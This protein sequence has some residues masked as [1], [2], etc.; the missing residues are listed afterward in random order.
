MST[1]ICVGRREAAI[2]AVRHNGDMA[3]LTVSEFQDLS[4]PVVLDV[5][6]SLAG[7]S[8]TADYAAGR[9]PGAVFVDFDGEICGPPGDGGR[10][11]LPDPAVLEATLRRVGVDD[12]STV[13]VYDA[14]DMMSA[15][16]TWWTLKWA[17]L[18]NVHVL[19]G[20]YAAAVEAGLGGDVTPV[21]T[22]EGTTTV[23]PGILPV[24]DAEGAFAAANEGVLYDVR[25]PARFRGDDG[26]IDPVAGHVP[27]AVNLPGE[28]VLCPD[29]V[30][31]QPVER[32]A[33][34]FA[35]VPAIGAGLYCGSGVTA[36]RTALAATV[37]GLA[38]PAVYIGSWSE[39]IRDE[40]RPVA[41]GDDGVD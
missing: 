13:V 3:L 16:R 1:I 28:E 36:A 7:G 12:D 33:E 19:D 15:S 26:V 35:G 27:G 40:S 10:H 8:G 6:W 22:A 31:F 21:Q 2:D 29:G 32:L 38:T 9:L 14:G 34:I 20:G 41:T 5:R 17:G 23:R 37:A 18:V 30:G 25:T 24:L 39:W 4:D 11:P